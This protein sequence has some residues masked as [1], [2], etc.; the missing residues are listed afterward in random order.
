MRVSAITRTPADF[1][2]YEAYLNGKKIDV[3]LEADEEEGWAYTIESIASERGGYDI[4]TD[5]HN[6]LIK[7]FMFG[8]VEIREVAACLS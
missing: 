5:G 7:T 4:I 3:C 1:H 2:K 6:A 8:K